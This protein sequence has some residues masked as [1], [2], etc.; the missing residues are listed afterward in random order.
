MSLWNRFNPERNKTVR[1]YLYFIGTGGTAHLT[2]LTILSIIHHDITM[3]SPIY[4]IDLEKIFPILQQ[5]PLTFTI[6]WAVTIGSVVGIKQ[7]LHGRTLPK[8][9]DE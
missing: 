6:A 3:A 7:R 5:N 9:N 8:N 1:A 2:T 4:A